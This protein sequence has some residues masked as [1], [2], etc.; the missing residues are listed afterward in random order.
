MKHQDSILAVLLATAIM[1]MAA[2]VVG[3]AVLIII[4][5]LSGV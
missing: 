1:I 5:F 3:A 4:G 2:S